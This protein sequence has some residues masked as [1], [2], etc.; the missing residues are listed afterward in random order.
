M[1]EKMDSPASGAG[2]TGFEKKLEK[3]ISFKFGNLRTK[4]HASLLG[5]E[6]FK[7]LAPKLAAHSLKE[8]G[9]N[10]L[11]IRGLEVP[12]CAKADLLRFAD[13]HMVMQC[14]AQRLSSRHDLTGHLNIGLRRRGIA[15]GM[16]VHHDQ[17]ACI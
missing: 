14:H 8:C 4:K 13:N 6:F 7:I 15:R 1:N 3:E 5:Q 11:K 16:I 10:L 17:R 12:V 9:R 2:G